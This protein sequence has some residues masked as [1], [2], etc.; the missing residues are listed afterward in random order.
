[1]PTDLA[2]WRPHLIRRA[3]E[4]A[5]K[6][7]RHKSSGRIVVVLFVLLLALIASCCSLEGDNLGGAAVIALRQTNSKFHAD[8]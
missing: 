5:V 2:S 8:S 6:D 7:D 1:M 3:R 4:H